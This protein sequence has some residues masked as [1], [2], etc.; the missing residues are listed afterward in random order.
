[1]APF[2]RLLEV[3]EEVEEQVGLVMLELLADQM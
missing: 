3:V 2:P 1:L